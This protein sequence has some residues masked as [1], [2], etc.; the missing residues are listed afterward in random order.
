MI[1]FT[2]LLIARESQSSSL[3]SANR[4]AI[5]SDGIDEL[6]ADSASEESQANAVRS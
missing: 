6:A 4:V 1:R 2:E 5:L 3:S